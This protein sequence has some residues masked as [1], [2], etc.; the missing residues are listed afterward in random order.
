MHLNSAHLDERF[1][2]F[3]TDSDNRANFRCHIRNGNVTIK[4]K[5][6]ANSQMCASSLTT[7]SIFHLKTIFHL[8]Q[9]E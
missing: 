3:K 6:E 8:S 4:A 5:T 9:S 2:A 1:C 7:T